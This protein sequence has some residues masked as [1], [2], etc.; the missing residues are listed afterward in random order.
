MHRISDI[1][2][3]RV[4]GPNRQCDTGSHVAWAPMSDEDS[5]EGEKPTE[6]AP[7]LPPSSKPSRFDNENAHD[8]SM[9]SFFKIN[10]QNGDLNGMDEKTS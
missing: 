1:E 4:K 2:K 8:K 7:R 5:P 9:N 3:P 10:V 6:D